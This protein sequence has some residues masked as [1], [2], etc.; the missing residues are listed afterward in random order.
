MT[1][2][3]EAADYDAWFRRQV[4]IGLEQAT[5]GLLIPAEEVEAEFAARR[6]ETRRRLRERPSD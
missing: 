6:Q 4:Q 5:A 3:D 1:S 2:I